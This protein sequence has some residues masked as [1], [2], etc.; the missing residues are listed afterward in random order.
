MYILKSTVTTKVDGNYTKSERETYHT[1]LGELKDKLRNKLKDISFDE[2][3]H[4]IWVDGNRDWKY[5]D[6]SGS[7][8]ITYSHIEKAKVDKYL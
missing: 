2:R 3:S 5:E 7:I 6:K 8:V 4:T 1:D